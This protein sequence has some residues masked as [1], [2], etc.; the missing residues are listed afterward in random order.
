M[1]RLIGGRS[2]SL[3]PAGA[4]KDSIVNLRPSRRRTQRSR[5]ARAALHLLDDVADHGPLFCGCEEEAGCPS[6]D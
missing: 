2:H 4:G 1:D 3:T 6:C 5:L